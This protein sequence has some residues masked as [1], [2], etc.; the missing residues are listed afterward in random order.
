MGGR[1]IPSLPVGNEPRPVNLLVCRELL[2]AANAVRRVSFARSLN[3]DHVE[4]NL[5]HQFAVKC[6]KS[7]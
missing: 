5:A 2:P 4:R 7:E 6:E 3:G 1:N